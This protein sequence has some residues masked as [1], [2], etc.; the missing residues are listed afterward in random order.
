MTSNSFAA[1]PESVFSSSPVVEP[2]DNGA[3]TLRVPTALEPHG[4]CEWPRHMQ[5]DCCKGHSVEA[6]IQFASCHTV[7]SYPRPNSG[8][9]CRRGA[10]RR[11]CSRTFA[12]MF[13]DLPDSRCSFL[14]EANIERDSKSFNP[15]ARNQVRQIRGATTRASLRTE[16]RPGDQIIHRAEIAAFN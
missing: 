6:L 7:D 13:T 10:P 8:H 16:F 5:C 4:N 11:R 3:G 14:M 2:S 15:G 9:I 1:Q 12:E